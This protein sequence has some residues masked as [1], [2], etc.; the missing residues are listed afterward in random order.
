MP[1]RRAARRARPLPIV[2]RSRCVRRR[3]GAASLL[4]AVAQRRCRRAAK[5]AAARE[6]AAL[7]G[8]ALARLAAGA[9]DITRA[10][11]TACDVLARLDAVTRQRARAR[12]A[13]DLI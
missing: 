7:H 10:R 3:R 9:H 1:V 11:V 8:A 12:T 13:Q 2:T 4:A 6:R 5:A